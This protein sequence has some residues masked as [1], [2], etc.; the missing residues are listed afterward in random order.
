MLQQP[1]FDQWFGHHA[2]DVL[3]PLRQ[4]AQAAANIE[5]TIL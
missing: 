4:V 5:A 1:L 2:E 3:L